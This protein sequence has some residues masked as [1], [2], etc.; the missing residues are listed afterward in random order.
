MP[1]RLPP[2]VNN[3]MMQERHNN[4]IP[5]PNNQTEREP[6][7]KELIMEV[8]NMA[9]NGDEDAR[10]ALQRIGE[11]DGTTTDSDNGKFL[12]AIA[13]EFRPGE[14]ATINMSDG[15][16]HTE[17]EII[18][19][20]NLNNEEIEAMRNPNIFKM[21]I[22]WLKEKLFD[23]NK[24]VEIQKKQIENKQLVEEGKNSV[25]CGKIT[26]DENASMQI[27]SI[28]MDK[29]FTAFIIDNNEKA[30]ILIGPNGHILT[31]NK[32]YENINSK[33]EM[34]TKLFGTKKAIEL[35]TN[36]WKLCDANCYIGND[37][38]YKQKTAKI[39]DVV[40]YSNEQKNLENIQSKN[41]ACG[42][43]C[44]KFVQE[45]I[46]EKF[47]FCQQSNQK[48]EN[49][50]EKFLTYL[51]NHK[52]TFSKEQDVAMQRLKNVINIGRPTS[53]LN[54]INQQNSMYRT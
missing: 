1:R 48:I 49:K 25:K 42:I 54:Y 6:T 3:G 41:G 10:I 39:F 16:R 36:G 53:S 9:D 20:I 17:E 52:C 4:T 30:V 15:A 8:Q 37:E 51:N 45:Y 47:K 50:M 11:R 34:L 28:L 29:H 33:Q 22:M 44:N 40:A 24:E 35:M 21:I 12:K 2:M 14:I 32:N 46:D 23:F 19:Q 5:P 38:E 7:L 31:E 26:I 27:G 13:S 43:I 18:K